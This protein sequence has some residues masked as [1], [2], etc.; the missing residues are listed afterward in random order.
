LPGRP[1]RLDIVPAEWIYAAGDPIAV[2]VTA[3]SR[4]DVS[5]RAATAG[6]VALIWYRPPPFGFRNQFAPPPATVTGATTSLNLA[7]MRAGGTAETKA[8]VQ[9]WARAPSGTLGTQ[10]GVA[11]RLRAELVL[12]DGTTVGCERPIRILSRRSL[13]QDVE[14]AP[15]AY[16]QYG[17]EAW[18]YDTV[19]YQGSWDLALRLP[20]LHARADETLRGVFRVS[21]HQAMRARRVLVSLLMVDTLAGSAAP[22]VISDGEYCRDV[23]SPMPR[24]RRVRPVRL[25]ACTRLAEPPEFPFTIRLPAD[26][27]PTIRTRYRAVRWYVRGWVRERSS[28]WQVCDTEI[29]IFT[30]PG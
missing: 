29:N 5:V 13:N 3:A 21:P 4:R 12:D 24:V 2:R 20:A 1:V 27:C 14:G 10:L 23:E 26:A 16:R 11:Y 28:Q 22:S 25:A 9:N 6:L 8:V 7:G 15:L 19:R 18:R 30:G 17:A